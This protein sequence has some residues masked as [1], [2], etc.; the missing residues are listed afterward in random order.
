MKRHAQPG[1]ILPVSHTLPC[2][3]TFTDTKV[4]VL[5]N[6]PSSQGLILYFTVGEKKIPL[7]ASERVMFLSHT[8]SPLSC[9]Q[10]T[11]PTAMRAVVPLRFRQG[12]DHSSLGGQ[13]YVDVV[14]VI[15]NHLGI[16]Q[17]SKYGM[18]CMA[19]VSERIW[20]SFFLSFFSSDL[21]LIS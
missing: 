14:L 12:I 1:N 11:C 17:D 9:K 7:P 16:R 8:N 4:P 10:F 6:A 5:F 15:H 3:N 20:H 21:F 18:A 19:V 13:A 2:S